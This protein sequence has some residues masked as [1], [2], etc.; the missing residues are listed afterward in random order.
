M[1]ITH[2]L[3]DGTE[4]TLYTQEELA[5]KDQA[6]ASRDAELEDLRKQKEKLE[7]VTREKTENIRKLRDMTEQEKEQMS[8][9]ELENRKYIE[10]LEQELESERSNRTEREKKE[11][12]RLR[13]SVIAGYVGEDIELKKKFLD[14]Y[15]IIAIEETDID[16]IK[17]RAFRAAKALDISPGS[18]YNPVNAYWGDGIPPGTGAGTAPKPQGEKEKT[19]FFKSGKGADVLKHL[20]DA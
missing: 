2:K 17:A 12:E 4:T 15:N 19:E 20:G 7:I 13:N 9:A 5:E 3:D 8:Q 1:P 10:K 11:T 6:I 14:E 18:N 16:S